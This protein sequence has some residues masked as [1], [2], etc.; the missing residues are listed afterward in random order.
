MS[1]KRPAILTI[2]CWLHVLLLFWAAYAFAA[3]LLF[4]RESPLRLLLCGLLP[5]VPIILGWVLA[6]KIRNFF[7]YSLAGVL[8]C[9]AMGILASV[10]SGPEWTQVMAGVVLTVFFTFLVF[11]L[12]ANSKRAYGRLKQEYQATHE[13]S[14]FTIQEREMDNFLKNPQ[15][16]HL[17]WFAGLYIF[18][19]IM[20]KRG[21]LIYLFAMTL[22]DIV[23]LSAYLY[24]SSFYEYMRE[25]KG[26]ANLP[27]ATMRRIHR[28]FGIC[29]G[30]LLAMFLLPSILFGKE[31]TIDFSLEKPLIEV[32]D[33]WASS[34]GANNGGGSGVANALSELDTM[35]T[36]TLPSWV[37]SLMQLFVY[38]IVVVAAVLAVIGV[39]HM[40]RR[41]KKDF[42]VE[43]EDEVVNLDEEA[44]VGAQRVLRRRTHEGFLSPSQ[45]IRRRYRR[46][47]RRAAKATPSRWGTPTE[48]E[49]QAAV[50]QDGQM[51]RLHGYYEKARYSEG[52]CTQEDLRS[53]REEQS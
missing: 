12:Y 27:L 37:L 2:A 48:I 16:T 40:I 42:A 36:R 21:C 47:I 23:V 38:L 43:E 41:F 33:S 20:D 28:F 22:A 51:Q 5:I 29:G 53:L 31:I 24:G 10:V 30:L 52:G 9:I 49:H 1:Y 50:A 44:P 3:A 8:L 15:A 34:D 46:V 19:I 32:E 26:A 4:E 45:Q 6:P 18:A 13:D 14:E 7:L 17:W 35:G 25:K 39:V 11:F